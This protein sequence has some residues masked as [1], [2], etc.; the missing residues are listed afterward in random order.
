MDALR[1]ILAT[2]KGVQL[3]SDKT[4]GDAMK[5]SDELKSKVEGEAK[6][7]KRIDTRYFSDGGVEI[8]VEMTI[9]GLF[10][11]LL[12]DGDSKAAQSPKL[13][14]QGEMKNTGLVVDCMGLK[15]KPALAPRILDESG[16]EVYAASVVSKDAIKSNGIA[17][18]LKT[19]DE[20]KKSARVGEKPLVLKAV[21]VAGVSDVVISNA[22]A[23]KLTDPKGNVTYLAEGRVIIVAE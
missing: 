13:P 5:S 19:M 11:E 3:S 6:G 12:T 17:G 22:D 14:S 10:A 8:D 9:E 15:P 23:A 7:F 4:V 18:Y 2:I 1:N 16:K 20:A 21:K